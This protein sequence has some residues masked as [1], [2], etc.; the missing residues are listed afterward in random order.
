MANELSG[1]VAIITGGA[2]GLGRST[3]ELFSYGRLIDEDFA[4]FD[5]VMGGD[6]F[7]EVSRNWLHFPAE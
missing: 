2:N 1:K 5:R 4:K 7:H 6:S 3:A